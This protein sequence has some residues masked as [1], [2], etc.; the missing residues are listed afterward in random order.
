MQKG[1]NFITQIFF[2]LYLYDI[3]QLNVLNI[4]NDLFSPHLSYSMR[5]LMRSQPVG[6]LP[7]DKT[8]HQSSCGPTH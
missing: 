7:T 5:T 4:H 2:S 3:I 6:E 8:V 1:F